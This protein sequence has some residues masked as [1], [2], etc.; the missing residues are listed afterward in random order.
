MSKIRYLISDREFLLV[1]L[2]WILMKEQL[3]QLQIKCSSRRNYTYPSKKKKSIH[4]TRLQLKHFSFLYLR[5]NIADACL[6]HFDHVTYTARFLIHHET[7]STHKDLFTHALQNTCL[8]VHLKHYRVLSYFT[9]HSWCHGIR[10]TFILFRSSNSYGA[11]KV[12]HEKRYCHTA[13]HS[14]KIKCICKRN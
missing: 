11:E 2:I 14:T 5:I 9:A 7:S 10:R 8:L 1:L 3:L 6:F 4:K 13:D 12:G